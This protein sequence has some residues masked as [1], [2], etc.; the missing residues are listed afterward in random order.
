MTGRRCGRPQLTPTGW[1]VLTTSAVLAP[2]GVAADQP[3]LL[4]IGL[5]GALAFGLGLFWAVVPPVVHAERRIEPRRLPEGSATRCRITVSNPGRR[6]SRPAEVV[7]QETSSSFG[8]PG[9]P[10]GGRHEVGPHEIVFDRRGRHDLTPPLVARSDPLG[11]LRQAAAYGQPTV[12]S[13]YPRAHSVLVPGVD[14]RTEASRRASQAWEIADATSFHALR[15][16][17][18][19]DDYRQIHWMSSAR[20]DDLLVREER[21]LPQRPGCVVVLDAGAHRYQQDLFDEAVRVAASICISA[22]RSGV[23]VTLRTQA[24]PGTLDADAGSGAGGAD[25]STAESAPAVAT[26]ETAILDLL[27]MVTTSTERRELAA[28]L[29]PVP[30]GPAPALIVVTGRVGA[31]E[32]RALAQEARSWAAVHVVTVDA[33]EASRPL[34]PPASGRRPGLRP[35]SEGREGSGPVSVVRVGGSADFARQWRRR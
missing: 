24:R 23:L 5:S 21:A 3:E 11:L 18:P 30:S 16:Y 34:P 33:G 7:D 4:T 8:I 35:S 15:P 25:T 9:I 2:V 1:W 27:T 17:E 29:P 6:R 10:A 22:I 26:T 32:L 28:I 13:V 12:V 20:V 14:H 31:G 19:G